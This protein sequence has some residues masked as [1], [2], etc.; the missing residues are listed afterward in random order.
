M[1]YVYLL[2]SS[3][4]NKFYVGYSSNLRQRFYAH[5]QGMVTSTKSGVPWSIVYYEAYSSAKAAQVR[6]KRLKQYGK[7]LATL[8]KR[9]LADDD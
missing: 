7:A 4:T 9:V 2:R 8:K 5:N 1:Y 6:E 3:K